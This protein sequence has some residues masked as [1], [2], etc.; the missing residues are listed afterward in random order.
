MSITE[1]S[2]PP[3]DAWV[4][5]RLSRLI[6]ARIIVGSHT[7]EQRRSLLRAL[8]GLQRLPVLFP[9]LKLCISAGQQLLRLD[10]NAVEFVRFT[11]DWHTAFRLQYFESG[12]QCIDGNTLLDGDARQQAM[13]FHLDEFEHALEEGEQISIEDLSTPG[14]IDEP[15]IDEYLEYCESSKA[16]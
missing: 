7:V 14:Q 4:I 3:D 2:I 10:W 9:D 8:F 6:A 5:A 16:P 13:L 12:C 11:E 1:V 15:P